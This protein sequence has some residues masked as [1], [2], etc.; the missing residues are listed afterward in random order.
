MTD[1]LFETSI[2]SPLFRVPAVLPPNIIKY[3][4]ACNLSRSE[5]QGSILC[6][7]GEPLPPTQSLPP[8]GRGSVGASDSRHQLG[9]ARLPFC[10]LFGFL[11]PV[12]PPP[13]PL[14]LCM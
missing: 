11:L 9:P 12:L 2:C 8:T 5:S 7:H 13:P 14:L 4:K 6:Y 3:R 10:C 1:L